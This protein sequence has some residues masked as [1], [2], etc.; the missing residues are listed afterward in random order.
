MIR[1]IKVLV[2]GAL[3]LLANGGHALL[4]DYQKGLKAAQKDNYA[5]AYW[6]WTVAAEQGDA[7]AQLFLG[8]MFFEGLGVLQDYKVAM[9]WFKKSASSNISMAQNNLGLIYEQGRGVDQDLKEAARWYQK[10]AMQGDKNAQFNIGLM[11]EQGRGVTQ[12]LEESVQWYRQAAEQGNMLAQNNLGSIYEQGRG[13]DQDLKEAA[14]WYQ[15]AAVQGSNAAQFN[16]G[17]FYFN[18]GGDFRLIYSYIWFKMSMEN[19]IDIAKVNVDF[20]RMNMLFSHIEKADNLIDECLKKQKHYVIDNN[21]AA[22]CLFRLLA[23]L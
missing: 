3:L 4:A 18:E 7:V 15:K 1:F 17:A 16:L 6:E 21:G 2:F 11:Y 19:G 5:V 9:M 12:D 14:R 22:P 23:K 13:V 8:Q 20:L 10:A